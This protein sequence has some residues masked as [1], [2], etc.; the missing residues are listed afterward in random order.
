MEII[1]TT[2]AT[3]FGRD[4]RPHRIE[5]HRVDFYLPKKAT[6]ILL[7]YRGRQYVVPVQPILGILAR[8]L[9]EEVYSCYRLH[10]MKVLARVTIESPLRASVLDVLEDCPIINL[11]ADVVRRPRGDIFIADAHYAELKEAI[12]AAVAAQPAGPSR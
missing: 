8:A 2:V 10:D 9:E 11:S 4:S 3:Q 5:R 1:S 12:D 7:D 6:R